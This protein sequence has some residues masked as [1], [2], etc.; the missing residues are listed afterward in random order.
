M[1]KHSLNISV[2]PSPVSDTIYD[3]WISTQCIEDGEH[4]TCEP[5]FQEKI[6]EAHTEIAESDLLRWETTL[7]RRVLRLMEARMGPGDGGYISGAASN[8]DQAS[9]TLTQEM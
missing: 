5:R 1:L 3:V 8:G 4:K 7:V 6:Y 9:E 2:I